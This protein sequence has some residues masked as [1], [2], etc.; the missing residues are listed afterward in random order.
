M[1]NDRYGRCCQAKNVIIVVI[2]C[3]TGF[4]AGVM[5]LHTI[6]LEV[7]EYCVSASLYVFGDFVFSD[8]CL[9]ETGVG[10]VF[11]KG[12]S[13]GWLLFSLTCFLGDLC[14]PLKAATT[15]VATMILLLIKTDLDAIWFKH[16]LCCLH[17]FFTTRVSL[18]IQAELWA[19]LHCCIWCVCFRD[20]IGIICSCCQAILQMVFPF[21]F[22]FYNY[23][24]TYRVLY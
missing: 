8:R 10:K 22:S 24:G 20:A 18:I 16:Y 9:R 11:G 4:S 7:V 1:I 3:L 5:Y 23:S 6:W 21:L 15:V 13:Q 19:L 2:L 12:C 14:S 17:F